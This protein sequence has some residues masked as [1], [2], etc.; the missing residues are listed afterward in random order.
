MMKQ[1]DL[2]KRLANANAAKAG[3]I[4]TYRSAKTIDTERLKQALQVRAD[5]AEA[6]KQR[7]AIRDEKKREEKAY[8]ATQTEKALRLAREAAEVA[9]SEAA[10]LATREAQAAMI[11][12]IVSDHNDRK[13]SRDDRYAKRKA[14]A[15]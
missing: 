1:N 7:H 11:S 8:L 2:S 4:E 5:V 15:R 9:A 12:S 14:A 6:R 10:S 13:A 3:L